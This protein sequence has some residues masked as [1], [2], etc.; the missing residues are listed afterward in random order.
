MNFGSD[1]VNLKIAVDGLDP[2]SVKLSG[3]TKTVLTSGNVMDENSFKEPEKVLNMFPTF[4][5]FFFC[6]F[7]HSSSVV[8]KLNLIYDYEG[9]TKANMFSL[10]CLKYAG[11]S[12]KES[13]Q[14]W[15]HRHERYA[16]STLFHFI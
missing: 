13:L 9:C 12:S 4:L 7:V 6:A 3:S 14:I 5:C 1:T 11:C 15:R 16:L 2:N 10:T 8:L